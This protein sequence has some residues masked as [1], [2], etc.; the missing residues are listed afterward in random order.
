[1]SDM[2]QLLRDTEIQAGH[3]D[4]ARA[5]GDVVEVVF[6]RFST[7]S[8]PILMV[9]DGSR[10]VVDLVGDLIKGGIAPSNIWPASMRIGAVVGVTARLSMPSVTPS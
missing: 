1:M 3:L 5:T 10:T 7:S 4:T 8:S 9:P 2:T 6:F